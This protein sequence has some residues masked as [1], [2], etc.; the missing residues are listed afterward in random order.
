MLLVAFL[1]I[2][3]SAILAIYGYNALLLTILHLIKK[4]GPSLSST[5]PADWPMVTVQL[6]VYNERYVVE[7]LIE[8]VC[9]LDYPHDRL[10]IQLLDDS[11]ETSAAFN[12]ELVARRKAQGVAIDRI[13]RPDRQGYKAGALQNGLQNAAG[14]FIAIFDADFL[15]SPD[16]LLQTIPFLLADSRIGCV[17]ARWGH[18]NAES[19]W[20]ARAMSSGIDAHFLIEQAERSSHNLFLNFS[21][22]AG[23]W[24]KACIQTSG[25][26]QGDTLTEDLDLSYRAQ[27]SGWKIRYL[28]GVLVPAELPVHISVLKEQQF[29]WAK[30][31]TQVA[32]K[33]LSS[34]WNSHF[35]LATKLEGTIHLTNY[36]VY[37]FI[38]FN[39]LLT[40][41]LLYTKNP[42]L[43]FSP[44]F[45]G[46]VVGP[47][48]MNLAAMLEQGRPWHQCLSRL[49]IMLLLGVG[50][51]VTNSR[52]ILEA[53]AGRPNSFI[54][55]PKFNLIGRENTTHAI[56]KPLP[57]N[58]TRWIELTL[59]ILAFSLLIYGLSSGAWGLAL[60]LLLY[61]LGYGYI[62][63]LGFIETNPRKK[64]LE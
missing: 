14:D 56:D 50:F 7:R 62:T 63:V 12:E 43:W 49:G 18:L 55:T 29:R 17:Q 51:S 4:T 5:H 10:H 34:L 21:G 33:L 45:I 40:F 6:P 54:R 44:L 9:N 20:L 25:G 58:L 31:S 22:S 16:F 41:P 39:L 60:W 27:L 38:L 32:M 42:A 48:C 11:N 52:A 24:R 1:Y 64:M 30:G 23:V 35:P 13:H 59:S 37:P 26:W 61:A 57:H 53:A 46:A 19:C 2:L 36:T 3:S 15:P 8:A 47:I 28:P